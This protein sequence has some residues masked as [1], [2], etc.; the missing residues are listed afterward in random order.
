[1][2][3]FSQGIICNTN[4]QSFYTDKPTGRGCSEGFATSVAKVCFS[5]L[6]I[7]FNT[8]KQEALH[9]PTGRGCSEGFATSGK[10]AVLSTRNHLQHKQS[11]SFYTDWPTGRGCSDGFATSVA[12]VPFSIICNTNKQEAFTLTYKQRMFW[13]VCHKCGIGAASLHKES[14]ATQLIRKVFHGLT[15]RQRTFWRVCHKCGKGALLS[16][17]NHLQHK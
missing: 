3:F 12:N 7:I 13:R 10:G 14:F 15:Y 2:P 16:T 6:W 17:R 5:Q 4:K 9:W 8:N 1:M 11:G